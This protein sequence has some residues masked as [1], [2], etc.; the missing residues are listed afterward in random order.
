MAHRNYSKPRSG[1]LGFL[2]KCRCKFS[3]PQ[4]KYFKPATEEGKPHVAGFITFKAGCTHVMGKLEE[5]MTGKKV[6]KQVIRQVTVL[7]A[8]PMVAIGIVGYVRTP[9]GYKAAHTVWAEHIGESVIKRVEGRTVDKQFLGEKGGFH[10]F[11]THN[12]G[13]DAKKKMAEK[14]A[15]IKNECEI[16]KLICHTQPEKTPLAVRRAHIIEL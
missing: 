1:H 4:I 16:I 6:I 12:K 10:A 14:L 2:P 13:G 8:P 5:R 15:L 9:A 3:R 7:D 11:K